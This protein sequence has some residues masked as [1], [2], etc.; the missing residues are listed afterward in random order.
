MGKR[1]SGTDII[2]Q[3]QELSYTVTHLTSTTEYAFQIV[4]KNEQG[5]GD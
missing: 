1:T 3:V 5:W 2:G 4:A